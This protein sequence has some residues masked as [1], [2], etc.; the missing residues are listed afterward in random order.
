MTWQAAS[1]GRYQRSLQ[2][3]GARAGEPAALHAA[4]A[5]PHQAPAPAQVRHDGAAA[6]AAHDHVV[7]PLERVRRRRRAA[8]TPAAQRSAQQSLT[9]VPVPASREHHR[10]SFS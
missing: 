3:H 8:R 5:A 4:L 2:C 7:H 10:G 6:D 9:R 1:G